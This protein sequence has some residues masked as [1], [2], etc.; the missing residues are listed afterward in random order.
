MNDKEKLL[1]KRTV[2]ERY[3]FT[4]WTLEWLIR[5]RQIGGMVRVGKRRIFF[6][7]VLLDEWIGENKIKTSRD[8]NAKGS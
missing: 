7:P 2:L 8:K 1:D 6:D 3:H 5:T 4:K